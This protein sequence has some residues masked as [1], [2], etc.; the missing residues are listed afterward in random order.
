[1]V[2]TGPLGPVGERLSSEAVA[3]LVEAAR[4]A[5][6]RAISVNASKRSSRYCLRCYSHI[7]LR[8]VEQDHLPH[9][10]VPGWERAI[11]AATTRPSR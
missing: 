5:V 10:P 7:T 9:C 11:E 3:T 4:Y 1:M 2:A 6:E 8:G